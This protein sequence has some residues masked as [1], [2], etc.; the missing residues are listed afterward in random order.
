MMETVEVSKSEKTQ[1]V[2]GDKR[3]LFHVGKEMPDAGGNFL[4]V[5][6]RAHAQGYGV[7]CAD[8]PDLR[9]SGGEVFN[10]KLERIPI[11]CIPMHGIWRQGKA[12]KGYPTAHTEG[13]AVLMQDIMY[14][15]GDFRARELAEKMYLPDFY[16]PDEMIKLRVYYSLAPVFFDEPVLKGKRFS[17]EYRDGKVEFEDVI[18]DLMRESGK[19]EDRVDPEIVREKLLQT[20]QIGLIPSIPEMLS[21]LNSTQVD[22]KIWVGQQEKDKNHNYTDLIR[23]KKWK[24]IAK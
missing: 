20:I 1:L 17:D 23:V 9:Y 15:D 6:S 7:Y 4:M 11:Y 19:Y 18:H 8:R 16:D 12:K 22:G 5:S 10:T 3:I 2:V 24:I 13:R 21:K 14:A